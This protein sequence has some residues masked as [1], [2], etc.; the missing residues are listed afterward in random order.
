M[1]LERATKRLKSAFETNDRRTL[2]NFAN[3]FI[4]N[5]YLFKKLARAISPKDLRI[6][7]S[8]NK[9][10]RALCEEYD[11]IQVIK[12][13]ELGRRL[14]S[15]F[16]NYLNDSSRTWNI[17]ATQLEI[18]KT[19]ISI[20]LDVEFVFINHVAFVCDYI[21]S[22]ASMYEQQLFD[23]FTNAYNNAQLDRDVGFHD[24][25]IDQSQTFADN[26]AIVLRV[27][28]VNLQDQEFNTVLM[29]IYSDILEGLNQLGFLF[30]I[31]DEYKALTE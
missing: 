28:A 10:F 26:T 25:Q 22:N 23:V 2:N 4:H 24:L 15:K 20:F 21:N 5:D 13:S 8:L 14:T 1:A 27:D 31:P 12:Q 18:P 3:I 19:N 6:L 16:I 30:K 7:C 9:E 29:S 17:F 11:W